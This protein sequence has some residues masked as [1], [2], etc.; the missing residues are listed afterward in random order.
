MKIQPIR[1]PEQWWE[2]AE[3]EEQRQKEAFRAF[4]A[5][6]LH[7]IKVNGVRLALFFGAVCV[8]TVAVYWWI[9]APLMYKV[10]GE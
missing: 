4:Y 3:R 8:G 9:F 7:P 10:F 1:S 2:I 6:Q 5:R